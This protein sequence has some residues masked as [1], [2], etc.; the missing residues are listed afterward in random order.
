MPLPEDPYARQLALGQIGRQLYAA[1]GDGEPERLL[2]DRTELRSILDVDGA[3]RVVRLRE[4]G[5]APGL[6]AAEQR[7]AYS[8][9]T[10]AGVCFDRAREEQAG[11]SFGLLRTAFVFERAL[12]VATQPDGTNLA[13]WLEGSFVGTG[14][15]VI[16]LVLS[17][18][19]APRRE[20]T[21]LEILQCDFADGLKDI[22]P[23]VAAP[24]P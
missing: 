20:H 12:I 13:A 3:M 15:L 8:G 2:V 5:T 21:D 1:V 7:A 22:R 6:S 9:T 18:V 4:L 10:Y 24:P 23:V 11:S 17:R 16:A 14:D 19:E